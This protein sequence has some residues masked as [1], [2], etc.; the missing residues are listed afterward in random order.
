MSFNDLMYKLHVLVIMLFV[1]KSKDMFFVRGCLYTCDIDCPFIVP[2][3]PPPLPPQN[4]Q[5]IS[6]NHLGLLFI[7][8]DINWSKN[9]IFI[10]N[11]I[12]FWP[13]WLIYLLYIMLYI[14]M[15]KLFQGVLIGPSYSDN[16]FFLFWLYDAY[17]FTIHRNVDF[18]NC[19]QSDN[20][21]LSQ[22]RDI[23]L[24][25]YNS[26]FLIDLSIML[27]MITC[28]QLIFFFCFFFRE[29]VYICTIL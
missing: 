20:V 2:F 24:L 10:I 29:Y 1:H 12:F 8:S 3:N 13:I 17:N 4:K 6:L 9:I 16:L 26:I 23:K 5:I 7:F 27:Y 25:E 22:S 19:R 15:M 28:A 18:D 14:K 11:S 21:L